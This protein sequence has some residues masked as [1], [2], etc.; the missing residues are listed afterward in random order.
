M[1]NKNVRLEFESVMSEDFFLSKSFRDDLLRQYGELKGFYERLVDEVLYILRL[2]IK[3]GKIKI[4]SLA[5]RETKIKT[6]KSFYDNVSSKQIRANPFESVEDIAGVRIICLYRS[7]LQKIGNIISANFELVR[8]DTS[9]TRTEA[10]FGYSSDHYV[11]KLPKECKGPRYDGIKNLKCEIQVRTIP[12]DA[13]ASVSHHLE[14]KHKVDI[15]RELR[16]TFNALAGL[17]Y[18]ADSV[19]ELFK[20]GIEES[21]AKL[22][23][24]I[25]RDLF[26]LD[27]EINYESIRA[28]LL[29]KFPTRVL[30]DKDVSFI[31]KELVDSGYSNIRQLDDKLKAV[32]SLAEQMEKEMFKDDPTIGWSAGGIVRYSLDLADDDYF[33][34]R[35]PEGKRH[36]W[37]PDIFRLVKKYRSKLRS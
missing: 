36:D 13:W 6:F 25:R 12:M 9:R 3:K 20:E 30:T 37:S 32:S 1:Q 7:D 26:D 35:H 19:F 11:I 18:V 2:A 28:Y 17:F 10:P 4:H 34:R 27:E 14:Y 16:A 23:K 21:R 33:Y 22:G 29:S 15:P 8:M 31:V 5:P 24:A